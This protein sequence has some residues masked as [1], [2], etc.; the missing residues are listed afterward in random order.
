MASIRKRG[1]NS[2]QII[3]SCG[4][5]INNKKL[6][7]TKTVKR[8]PGMTD[9]QWEKELQ[10]IALEFERRVETGQY[11]D[12]CKMTFAELAEYWITK[13]AES[14][15][16]PKTVQRYK[17]LLN[18]RI[19]PAIGHIRADKVQPTHLLDF[20]DN[21]RE[22]GIRLDEKY[23]ATPAFLK[24]YR[25]EIMTQRK[26]MEL[27][28][29]SESTAS[30]IVNGKTIMRKTAQKISEALGIE[31][32]LL[33]KPDGE[34][35]KLSD[36]TISHHHKLISSIFQDAV[37]WQLL[38]SN[39]AQK[40]KA[41]SF[42]RKPIKYYDDEQIKEL[43]KAIDKEELKYK[44]MV[45]LLIFVGMRIGE[46][47]GL[48]WPDIDFEKNTIHINKASQ[49]LPGMGTFEKE[50]KTESSIRDV[51]VPDFVMT[52]L[53]EYRKWWLE[54]RMACGDMWKGSNRLFV[55]WDGRP[56]YPYTLTKWFPKF[57]K[58]H[59]LPH[60]TPHGLRHSMASLL[61]AKGMDVAAVSKRLGH[62]KISTTLDIYTHV[63]KKA[64]K[65]ASEVLEKT[66]LNDFDES[67]SLHL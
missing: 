30:R 55:T 33:F 32:K 9:K 12:G 67:N 63:F 43:L 3:V 31:F 28:G 18:T 2:Y 11:M 39:P 47:M 16:E 59:N 64:D 54:Q 44:V 60:I 24:I 6:T 23:I 50:T 61:G 56:M 25:E 21:L 10:K 37:E 36:N 46:L 7:K 51:I 1:K 66:L 57:L 8:P 52:L 58:K 41:P 14:E 62:A 27:V 53:K 5:D 15:L 42:K 19:L 40:I 4:Y 20:Y 17:E 65:V 22:E 35:G 13:Y 29:I 38:S 48:D 34:P 45:I 49:Y 26:L